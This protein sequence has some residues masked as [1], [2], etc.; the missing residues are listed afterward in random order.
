[1]GT[2]GTLETERKGRSG[3]VLRRVEGSDARGGWE[4][5]VDK[6]GRLVH[7]KLRGV[8]HLQL[9]QEFCAKVLEFGRA[10]GGRPWSIVADSTQFGAQSPD[11]ARL[12]Q[13]TMSKVK[14]LGCDK[15]AAV[16]STVIYA[17]QFKRITEESHV[18]GAVFQDEESAMAWIHEER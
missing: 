5:V 6:T 7:L 18:G 17:M 3:G 4:I 12:R 14:A 9:A 10:F 11:V 1:M 13:E 16:V 2:R 15:I 8:W